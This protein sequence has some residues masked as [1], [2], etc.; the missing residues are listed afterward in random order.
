MNIGE[1][2]KIFMNIDSDEYT[3]DQKATAILKVLDMP[4]HN[5][6][7]KEMILTVTRWLWEYSFE[8]ADAARD[9]T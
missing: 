9:V 3:I 7:T 1:A 5:G 2:L 8:L 6:V 4:T